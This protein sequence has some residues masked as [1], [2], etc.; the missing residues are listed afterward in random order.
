MAHSAQKGSPAKRTGHALLVAVQYS[1][2]SQKNNAL[3]AI[4][5]ADFGSKGGWRP[6][7]SPVIGFVTPPRA[8]VMRWCLVWLT[9]M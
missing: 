7:F 6:D 1:Q 9:H 4:W 2:K 8:A 3:F 5:L